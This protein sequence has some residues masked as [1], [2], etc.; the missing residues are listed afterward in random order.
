MSPNW[1]R[2]KIVIEITLLL[3]AILAYHLYPLVQ[4]GYGALIISPEV[5]IEVDL[6]LIAHGNENP[7][8]HLNF[9]YLGYED[10]KWLI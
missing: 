8:H 6:V 9:H 4:V 3:Q 2:T 7:F 10:V 5:P 1:T